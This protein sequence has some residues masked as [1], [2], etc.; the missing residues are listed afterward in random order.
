MN[1]DNPKHDVQ[2]Q[3]EVTAALRQLLDQAGMRAGVLLAL[4]DNGRMFAIVAT[5]WTD[6]AQR[7]VA[8][9]MLRS[10]AD[11]IERGGMHPDPRQ[12]TK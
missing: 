8:L 5:P 6:E 12:G 4:T 9:V 3:L 11:A 1:P 7:D 10:A 2:V